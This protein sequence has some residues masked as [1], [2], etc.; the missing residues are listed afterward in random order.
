[1]SEEP[2][3]TLEEAE[4]ELK[5]RECAMQGH[6][7]DVQTLIGRNEPESVIWPMFGKPVA[8]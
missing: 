6:S 2:R 8:A 7:Y 1:V 4:L 3:Y 5:R